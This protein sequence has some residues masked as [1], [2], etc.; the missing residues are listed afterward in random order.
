MQESRNPETLKAEVCV[1]A[2]QRRAPKDGCA[3]RFYQDLC[4][5]TKGDL[6]IC[7]RGSNRSP[8]SYFDS[9][10]EQSRDREVA[11]PY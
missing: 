6:W 5:R 9:E 3:C 2:E 4:Q 1:V 11:E 10:G 8:K 7:S